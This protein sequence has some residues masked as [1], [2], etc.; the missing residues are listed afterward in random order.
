MKV[1]FGGHYEACPEGWQCLSEQEQDITKTLKYEDNSLIVIYL[2]HI[3][4]HITLIENISFL[5]EALR[6]LKIGGVLR[7]DMP[8]IDKMIKF[9]ND[10]IGKHF[11]DIQLSHYFAEENNALKKL[12]LQGISEEPIQF[13]FHSLI[14]F[15]NHKHVWTSKL[16]QKVLQKIGFSEVYICE[17]GQTNF[18]PEYCL[19]RIV[20]GV[21]PE[22]IKNE[23]GIEYYDPESMVIEAKK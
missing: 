18:N 6:I 11:A 5:K 3:N 19:E 20:R 9:K 8:C 16:M 15:H 1:L 17:P 10:G 14:K 4:E 22:Y 21:N 13:L 12:G 7:I 23:F 2:E